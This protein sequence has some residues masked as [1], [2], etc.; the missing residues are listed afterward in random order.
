MTLDKLFDI[1]NS[2]TATKEKKFIAELLLQ[3]IND[4][5]VEVENVDEYL[6]KVKIFLRI[7]D[8]KFE[9]IKEKL[10]TIDVEGCL[11]E[12][13]SLTSLLEIAEINRLENIS[14]ILESYNLI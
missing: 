7:S 14:N 13:E 5:P 2:T 6:S 8:L 11:W 10:E 3:S 9:I 12:T 1:V 4:W